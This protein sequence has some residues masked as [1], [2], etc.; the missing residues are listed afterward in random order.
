M[1]KGSVTVK[2][3]DHVE[4]GQSIG[5]VGLSGLTSFPHVHFMVHLENKP[6]DPFT[7][8][9]DEVACGD[10]SQS[11]WAPPVLA[12]LAYTPTGFLTAGFAD[13]EPEREPARNGAYDGT[14]LPAA[15]TILT[16][17]VD[18]FGQQK[19]D[20]RVITLYGP[21]GDLLARS[22]QIADEKQDL[23]FRYVGKRASGGFPPGIYRGEFTLTR[24]VDGAPKTV[25]SIQR[26][27]E[28]R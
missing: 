23:L 13:R 24:M 7:G 14:E 27:V 26:Q 20:Q 18:F 9:R 10:T 19:G 21:K 8:T 12:Q 22:E 1:M 3:G 16:F 2:P 11:L 5:I 28:L 17:W 15:A 4:A 25:I 6:V